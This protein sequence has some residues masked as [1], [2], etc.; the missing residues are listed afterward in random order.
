MP[1]LKHLV[2]LKKKKEKGYR[3]L[4]GSIASLLSFNEYDEPKKYK[5]EIDP[6]EKDRVFR[7]ID[8]L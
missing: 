1:Y 3:D 7:K 2:D 8:F 5:S 4:D 6:K